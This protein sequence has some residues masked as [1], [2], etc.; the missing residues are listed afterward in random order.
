MSLKEEKENLYAQVS[1]YYFTSSDFFSPKRDLSEEESHGTV[2]KTRG[3]LPCG[4]KKNSGLLQ[5]GQEPRLAP[6]PITGA[7]KHRQTRP[8][9]TRPTNCH[10]EFTAIVPWRNQSLIRA[11]KRWSCWWRLL[12]RRTMTNFPHCCSPQR[13][14]RRWARERGRP[15]RTLSCRWWGRRRWQT[16]LWVLLFREWKKKGFRW[17]KKV[18]FSYVFFY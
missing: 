15:R 13:C 3:L 14:W 1:K 12:H 8:G 7:A 11:R 4:K 2:L 18:Y 5:N 10:T 9:K 16:H 17:W 6:S